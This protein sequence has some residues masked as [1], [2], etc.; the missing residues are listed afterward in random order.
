M[1]SWEGCD[2][3]GCLPA[4]KST[5]GGR[6]A[7]DVLTCRP[8][9]AF[10]AVPGAARGALG[11]QRASSICARLQQADQRLRVV[12]GR[13]RTAICML[14]PRQAPATHADTSDNPS[15]DTIVN[16]LRTCKAGGCNSCR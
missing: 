1:D 12:S 4:C 3:K 10:V 6:V 15:P 14:G 16:D 2:C 5:R 9:K 8:V 7:D 13:N 11:L